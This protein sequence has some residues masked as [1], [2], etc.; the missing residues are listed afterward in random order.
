MIILAIGLALLFYLARQDSKKHDPYYESGP[1]HCM[2]V[3]KAMRIYNAGG[4]GTRYV[5]LE[6][7]PILTANYQGHV[8]EITVDLKSYY[9]SQPGKGIII[10]TDLY[11]IYGAP[12]D[13]L[14]P[15][16]L[17]MGAWIALAGWIWILFGWQYTPKEKLPYFE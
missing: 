13:W 14:P 3:A 4:S 15:G 5:D 2:V 17:W 7:R 10:Y 8:F 12:S 1:R 9:E 6:Y 16:L 11:D